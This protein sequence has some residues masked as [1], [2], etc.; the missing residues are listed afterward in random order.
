MSTITEHG[1]GHEK[2]RRPFSK[3]NQVPAAVSNLEASSKFNTATRTYMV[4]VKRATLVLQVVFICTKIAAI[5]PAVMFT[6]IAAAI[7]PSSICTDTPIALILPSFI[8]TNTSS[9]HTY[10]ICT[11]LAVI[12]P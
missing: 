2:L 11:N 9:H 12:T 7:I 5:L 6:N 4:N 10:L 8:C 1:G 3:T